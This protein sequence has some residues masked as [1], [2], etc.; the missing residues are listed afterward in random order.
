MSVFRLRARVLLALGLPGF[1]G[2][3]AAGAC[4]PSA[5]PGT[6]ETPITSAEPLAVTAPTSTFAEP[7]PD[8]TTSDAEAPL[9]V[10]DAGPPR[11]DASALPPKPE[12][13]KQLGAWFASYKLP[14]GAEKW[15]THGSVQCHPAS[16]TI[17]AQGAGRTAL[18]CPAVIDVACPCT[19]AGCNDFGGLC[20]AKLQT[21]V[22]LRE[23]ASHKDACCYDLPR[24]CVPPYVGRPFR[25]GELLVHAH[26][27]ERSDWLA[28]VDLESLR[29]APAAERQARAELW[30]EIAGLEHSSIASF[31]KVALD[32]LALGAPP[33]LVAATHH[34][35]LDE[36]EHATLAYAVAS[37]S[38]GVELGP[39]RL[40]IPGLVEHDLVSFAV[41]TF[42]DGCVEETTGS[43]VARD[44]GAREAEP[45]LRRVLARIA[46]DEDRHAELAWRMLGWAIDVGG[47]TV[48]RAV[49]AELSAVE[50]AETSDETRSAVLRLLVRPCVEALV[51]RERANGAL[52]AAMMTG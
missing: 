8:I 28:D 27:C 31:A 9:A 37:A 48:R 13:P 21:P 52:R 3:A 6:P 19:P 39:G 45:S 50:A 40:P 38:S 10:T 33:E 36:I 51:V 34:A 18:G 32:L 17:G 22:S 15:C 20:Q 49:E 7:P 11:P 44:L 29:S 24:Q 42:R 16:S 23:R 2:S 30:T 4:A 46:D 43:I 41:A 25:F 35:A 5:P 12:P 1:A 47:V 26:E 14:P